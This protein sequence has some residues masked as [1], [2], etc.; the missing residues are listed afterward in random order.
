[1]DR[2]EALAE[3]GKLIAGLAVPVSLGMGPMMGAAYEPWRK[4]YDEV[5]GFGYPPVEEE[6]TEA[7]RKVLG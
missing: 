5:V 1:M 7:V 2:E 3:V 6:M 4:L